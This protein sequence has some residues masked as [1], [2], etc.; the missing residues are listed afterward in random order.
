MNYN[1]KRT[2]ILSLVLS[3]F[4]LLCSCGGTNGTAETGKKTKVV[5]TIFP[6]YDFV[7]EIA[8]DTVE[9]TMLLS[10]GAE[11]HT[12]EPTP[13]DIIKVQS[14]D[15]FIYVGGESDSWVN[16]I[17]SSMDT[18]SM[19]IITL[20][21]C[22]E[23]LEEEIV[24]GMQTEQEEHGDEEPEYDEHVWTSPRN[25][26]LIT[27]KIN[28][29][30]KIASP[31]YAGDYDENTSDYLEKLAALDNEFAAVVQAGNRDTIVF[32]DRFPLRYFAEAYGLKYYAAYPGC[33]A[34]SE[35]SVSTVS[36]LIDKVKAEKFPA[37]FYIEFSNEQM[38]NTISE[39]TGAQKLLFHSCHN[40][41]KDDFMSGVSYLQLMEQN[42]SNL[43]IALQ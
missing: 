26:M 32:A 33:A 42:L 3:L 35:P 29:A 4:L 15:V 5:C 19:Q 18:S 10:P 13:Q 7:R 1:K 8:G 16:D 14:C 34:E 22:V 6:P 17:L 9:L 39:E 25:A 31:E 2:I 30:L 28:A 37:I 36:F 20:I 40:V 11:V 24:E 23:P 21:D 27:Q 43:K 41:S 12:Y 38:A